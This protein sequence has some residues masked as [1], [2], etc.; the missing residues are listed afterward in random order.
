MPAVVQ[1]TPPTWPKRQP[2]DEGIP[3]YG[4]T[5]P[6]PGPTY[7]GYDVAEGDPFEVEND[8]AD[9]R[10]RPH[11]DHEP[12]DHQLT[13]L[14]AAEFEANAR[15]SAAG[16]FNDASQARHAGT[17]TVA[18]SSRDAGTPTIA[19]TPL[20]LPAPEAP[21]TTPPPSSSRFPA[22]P[23]SPNTNTPSSSSRPLSTSA[24]YITIP[25]TY[26][27]TTA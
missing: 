3:A 22:G 9:Q 2:A 1:S 20:H 26:F 23:A 6:H 10:W 27:L 14:L 24:A 18:S 16:T 17:P 5:V 4:D 8:M 12:D 21:D 7:W 25:A 19:P 13:R 11:I 15:R